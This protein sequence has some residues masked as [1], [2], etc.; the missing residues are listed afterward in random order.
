[1]ATGLYSYKG[2]Q[3]TELPN[4]IRLSSGFTRTDSASFTEDELTDAGYTGPFP[5]PSF[6]A[7]TQYLEWIKNTSEWSVVDNPT[8]AGPTPGE[9]LYRLRQDRNSLL[10]GSDW[11][12]LPDSGLTDAERTAWTTYRQELREFPTQ[13]V[14]VIDENNVTI[15]NLDSEEDFQNITWPTAP[16][17]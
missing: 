6:D 17:A 1:M 9:L 5:K 12:L 10:E 15:R 4:E 7:E 13:F 14:T 2:Q 11:R 8:P 16:A 3:P